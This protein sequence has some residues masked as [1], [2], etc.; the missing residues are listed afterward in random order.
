MKVKERIE[1]LESAY[2][3]LLN[4]LKEKVDTKEVD[5]E[6]RKTAM[7]IYRLAQEDSKKIFEE[8]IELKDLKLVT[9]EDAELI[10]L[11]KPVSS[12]GL[13]PEQRRKK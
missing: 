11:H 3:Q 7:A 8:L 4:A 10:D 1:A 5:P 13:S 6:K 9:T 12:S 2:D